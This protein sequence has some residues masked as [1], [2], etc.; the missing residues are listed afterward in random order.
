MNSSYS[1]IACQLQKSST[2][3][4]RARLGEVPLDAALDEGDLVRR[5]GAAHADRAVAAEVLDESPVGEDAHDTRAY[6]LE[7][8]RTAAE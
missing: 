1:G 2:K 6:P 8:S 3:R 7:A 5:E 4:P